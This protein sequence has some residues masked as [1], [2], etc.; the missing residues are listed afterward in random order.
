MEKKLSPYQL[1]ARELRKN[2]LAHEVFGD[3][4]K[5]KELRKDAKFFDGLQKISEKYF[6]DKDKN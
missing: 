6:Y 5:A 3:E 4:E 2:A 1:H